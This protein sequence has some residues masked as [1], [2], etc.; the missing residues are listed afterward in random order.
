M[1]AV[2]M[3]AAGR[4][5]ELFDVPVPRVGERDVLVRDGLIAAIGEPGTIDGGGA[6]VLGDPH[7][8]VIEGLREILLKGAFYYRKAVRQPGILDKGG[9]DSLHLG[10]SFGDLVHPVAGNGEQ[11]QRGAEQ[12]GEK[13]VHAGVRLIIKFLKSGPGF[14]T[15]SRDELLGEQDPLGKGGRR[16]PM[17]SW[18][19]SSVIFERMVLS[20]SSVSAT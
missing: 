1:K 6:D 20:R 10:K 18:A 4:P 14:G 5:L 13:E 15:L 19:G 17:N 2:R 3:V 7:S 9:R 8:P 11:H 16:I 12:G